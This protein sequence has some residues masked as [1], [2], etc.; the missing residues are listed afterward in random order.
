MLHPPSSK[1]LFRAVQLNDL[2]LRGGEDPN[3]SMEKYAALVLDVNRERFFPTPDLVLSLGDLAHEPTMEGSAM[4]V[5]A[6]GRLAARA[7]LPVPGNH[8]IGEPNQPRD[9]AGYL[10]YFGPNLFNYTY[11]YRGVLFIAVN[12]AWADQPGIEGLEARQDWLAATL[13]RHE[14]QP[15]VILCHTPLVAVRDPEVLAASFDYPT[16]KVLDPERRMERLLVEHRDTI[17]AVLSGHIHLTAHCQIEGIHYITASGPISWP[18]DAAFFEFYQDRVE[19]H[20]RGAEEAQA[21]CRRQSTPFGNAIHDRHGPQATF[22][23]SLHPDFV[24]YLAGTARERDFVIELDGRKRLRP[25][26]SL[27]TTQINGF[28]APDTRTVAEDDHTVTIHHLGERSQV[29]L[30]PFPALP[31]SPVHVLGA[32]SNELYLDPD[33]NPVWSPEAL[34]RGVVVALEPF[35]SRTLRLSAAAPDP[36]NARISTAE[37]LR[38]QQPP[39]RPLG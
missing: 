4:A 33:D 13:A 9:Q 1:P 26:N 32:E 5:E 35:K 23:D 25:E 20:M 3:F 34:A 17:I 7:V 10:R 24:T 30:V 21:I 36:V 12:N 14:D 15:K 8:D 39:H 2:H 18:C 37:L 6:L 28:P 31:S 19:V 16:W 38:R 27:I 29:A 11:F 22:T